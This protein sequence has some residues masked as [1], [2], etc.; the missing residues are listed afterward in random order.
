MSPVEEKNIDWSRVSLREYN[1]DYPMAVP[2]QLC[3]HTYIRIQINV[4]KFNLLILVTRA[5]KFTSML[6][7]VTSSIQIETPILGRALVNSTL[8]SRAEIL[9]RRFGCLEVMNGKEVISI[10]NATAEKLGRERL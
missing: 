10:N 1:R 3:R 6:S 8:L 2:R 7:H 4:I 9:E 5:S